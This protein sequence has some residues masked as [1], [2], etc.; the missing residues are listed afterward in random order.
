MFELHR[1]LHRWRHLHAPS[2]VVFHPWEAGRLHDLPPKTGSDRN[3]FHHLTSTLQYLQRLC[4]QSYCGQ[5]E[6]IFRLRPP[7]LHWQQNHLGSFFDEV[8]TILGS[9]SSVRPPGKNFGSRCLPCGLF[10][11]REG[12]WLLLS[13]SELLGRRGH[14]ESILEVLGTNMSIRQPKKF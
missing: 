12:R 10:E 11:V 5:C 14:M 2:S 6:S 8:V 1:T 4:L 7:Y 3:P 13:L 9:F